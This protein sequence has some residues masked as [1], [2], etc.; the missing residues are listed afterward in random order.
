MGVGR[1]WTWKRR[2]GRG[3]RG[4]ADATVTD[5]VR[6]FDAG[7]PRRAPSSFLFGLLR[8]VLDSVRDALAGRSVGFLQAKIIKYFERKTDEQR[9]TE[10]F[11]TG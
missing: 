10:C 6:C 3:W 5:A 4:I 1:I 11:V 2:L 8:K 9:W 7:S